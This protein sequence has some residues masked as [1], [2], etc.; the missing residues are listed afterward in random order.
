MR[1]G[2]GG[3]RGD[4][5]RGVDHAVGHRQRALDIVGE[6][7]DFVLRFGGREFFGGDAVLAAGVP[8]GIEVLGVV[9]GQLDEQPAGLCDALAGD[10]SKDLVFGDALACAG[11]VGLG[12]PRAAV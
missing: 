3:R 10:L 8:L 9:L 7:G 5:P 1:S 2:V 4:Q 11:R 6:V 12:V